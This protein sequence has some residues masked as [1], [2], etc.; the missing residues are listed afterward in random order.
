[1]Y[2]S[3]EKIHLSQVNSAGLAGVLPETQSRIHQSREHERGDERRLHGLEDRSQG[4]RAATSA[5][6]SGRGSE[7]GRA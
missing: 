4:R 5:P 7:M 2:F 3:V 6:L 1:M